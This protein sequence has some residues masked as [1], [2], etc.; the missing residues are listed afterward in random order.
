MADSQIT[1]R[2]LAEAVKKLMAHV[3]F[4]KISV[5]D[6]AKEAGVNRQTFYYHFKDKYE[7]VNWIFY[8]ETLQYIAMLAQIELRH[9]GLLKLWSYLNDNRRFYINALNVSGQNSFSDY[10]TN[11][12]RELT[13]ILLSQFCES[14][15]LTKRQ[16]EVLSGYHAYALVGVIKE[17]LE[18]SSIEDSS[19]NIECLMALWRPFLEELEKV[20]TKK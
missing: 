6:I 10:L 18:K 15:S 5:G 9:E 11:Y 17:M 20:N 13:Q 1:K 7:L 12:I 19:A 3:P 8:T 16:H 4:S 14:G 2:V